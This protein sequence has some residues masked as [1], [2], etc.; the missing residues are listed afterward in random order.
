MIDVDAF[1]HKKYTA[2]EHENNILRLYSEF[3]S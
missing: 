3:L 2:K 1:N